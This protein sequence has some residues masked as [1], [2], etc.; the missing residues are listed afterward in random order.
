MKKIARGICYASVFMGTLLMSC[1]SEN[2]TNRQTIQKYRSD[3]QQLESKM[4]KTKGGG[5]IEIINNLEEGYKI[6]LWHNSYGSDM[7]VI[8]KLYR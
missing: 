1:G 4:Y 8:D 2:E 6:I 7:E 5:T 3:A